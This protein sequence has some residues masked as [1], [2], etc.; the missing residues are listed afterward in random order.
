[1]L[2]APTTPTIQVY[3]GDRPFTTNHMFPEHKYGI[4]EFIAVEGRQTARR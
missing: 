3:D 1:M 2:Y 4:H